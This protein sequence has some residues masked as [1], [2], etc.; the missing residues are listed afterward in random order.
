MLQVVNIIQAKQVE[1]E[2]KGGPLAATP[3]RLIFDSVV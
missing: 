1:N 3:V 2:S